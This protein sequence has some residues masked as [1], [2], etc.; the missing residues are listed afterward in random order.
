MEE[1]L[2]PAASPVVGIVRNDW[3]STGYRWC[4]RPES[5]RWSEASK[6]E[7]VSYSISLTHPRATAWPESSKI[8]TLGAKKIKETLFC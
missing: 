5:L 3:L 7:E 4:H 1:A 6:L 2:V 8:R